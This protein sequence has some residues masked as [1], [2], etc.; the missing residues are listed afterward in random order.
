MSNIRDMVDA[1]SSD[2]FDEARCALK[3]SLAEYMAG[4]KYLSN[5]EVFGSQY[6]N[7]NTDEQEMK[8]ELEG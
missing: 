4:K 8:D 5:E 7:P 6:S 2:N 1:I 3:A